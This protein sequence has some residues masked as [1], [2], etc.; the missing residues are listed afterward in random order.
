MGSQYVRSLPDRCL[1]DGVWNAIYRRRHMFRSLIFLIFIGRCLAEE[2][3]S[4]RNPFVAMAERYNRPVEI[5][6]HP[7]WKLSEKQL[8]TAIQ[9]PI[10]DERGVRVRFL[11]PEDLEPTPIQIKNG[12]A[13]SSRQR[14]LMRAARRAALRREAWQ[15]GMEAEN[16]NRKH[17]AAMAAQEKKG[18][19]LV[20]S[21]GKQ[22]G[23]YMDG[24][25]EL[26]CFRV[27]T[28][29]AST[30]TPKGHFHV[31]EKHLE[32]HS[33]LYNNASMPF[34]MRLTADGVGLHQG[35]V[36][37]WPASHG[38][39]RLNHADARFLFE[40]CEIGTPVFIID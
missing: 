17:S 9:P 19:H 12:Y 6:I 4:Y 16:Y 10:R 21:L 28:G 14:S 24:E 25:K 27:C 3:P 38:C 31:M 32:H 36:R 23:K 15:A 34:F 11:Y 2:V 5:A 29:K 40:R 37:S 8:N 7:S 39:V 1:Q 13:L 33:N 35:N 22:T 26:L 20:I 18:L 30:P